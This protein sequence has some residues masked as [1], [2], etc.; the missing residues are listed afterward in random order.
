MVTFDEFVKRFSGLKNMIR[1]RAVEIAL[2]QDIK[3][4]QQDQH[5]EG[6]NADSKIMQNGYSMGYSKLRKKKGLQTK[7]VDLHFSGKYH[8]SLK[9]VPVKDG[10]DITSD[11]DYEEFIRSN[12]PN[13]AGLT[14]DNADSIAEI[15]AN[16]LAVEIKKYLVG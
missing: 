9:V 4:M 2:T 3:K 12:F 16:Q 6:L 8:R 14:K 13:M 1:K 7:F 11:A 15:V 5:H 10:V